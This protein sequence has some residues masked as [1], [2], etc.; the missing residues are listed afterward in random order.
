MPRVLSFSTS[1]NGGRID[2]PEG[3][4]TTVPS[5]R[6]RDGC[7][8]TWAPKAEALL[9]R[10]FGIVDVWRPIR[11]PVMDSP[12]TLC[13]AR[14]FTDDLIASDLV[15]QH[16]RGETSSV[17]LEPGTSGITSPSRKADEVILARV[18]DPTRSLRRW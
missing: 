16:V 10:R 5:I 17:E 1:L 13:D 2:L 11:G 7:A 14:G 15:Y 8:T 4:T 9:G 12:L 6:R 18:H 3:Y